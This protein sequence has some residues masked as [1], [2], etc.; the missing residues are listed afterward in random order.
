M[1]YALLVLPVLFVFRSPHGFPYPSEIARYSDFTLTH[2]A[3]AL[4]IQKELIGGRGVPLWNPYIYSGTPFFANPL[5]GLTYPPGWLAL[6]FP[7]PFGLNFCLALHLW[8]GSIGMYTWLKANAISSFPALF[9]ATGFI[10]LPKVVAHYGAG[11]V[12]LLYAFA[13]TPWLLWA[14]NRR[15]QVW[16]IL[17]LSLVVLADV[18]WGIYAIFLWAFYYLYKAISRDWS[19][20]VITQATRNL[21]IAL[22]LCAPLLIPLVEFT[23]YS[24]RSDMRLE[25]HLIYS[26]PLERT[27]QFLFPDF[28]GFHEWIVYPGATITLMVL[29]QFFRRKRDTSAQFWMLISVIAL[30]F[31]YGGNLPFLKVLFSLPVFDLL[32]V[33]SRALFLVG[34]GGLVLAAHTLE[35]LCNQAG[36]FHLKRVNLFLFGLLVF[37]W[38]AFFGSWWLTGERLDNVLWGTI[39]VSCTSLL[40]LVHLNRHLPRGVIL[41]VIFALGLLD[42]GITDL[43]L[44]SV[45][46]ASDTTFEHQD[47]LEFLI[48]QQDG[49]F[50][51]YSP[52]YSLPQNLAVQYEIHLVEGVDPLQLKD[53]RTF[54][55]LASGVPYT[56][57][58]V[59]LPAFE[60]GNPDEDTR[61]Y[62]PNAPLLG[63]L[64]VRF[65]ISSFRL[66]VAGLRWLKELDQLYLYENEQYRPRAWLESGGSETERATEDVQIVLWTPNRIVLHANGPG[67]LVLS[68]MLYPSWKARVDGKIVN[69]EPVHEIFR[70]V[71]L[72]SGEHIIEFTIQ[73]WSLYLG[74]FL[75]VCALSILA[76]LKRRSNL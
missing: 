63:W 30:L 45:K 61:G 32:R 44:Y 26:F 17:F 51:V 11:H 76:L 6:L 52:T 27:L 39:V 48:D 59:T 28:G 72:D 75:S 34:L 36:D 50:R 42:W 23:R 64:N 37:C 5:S 10:L 33:P 71:Q 31:S 35:A 66:E 29:L 25:D 15:R 56:H 65:V 74:L 62:T 68:E 8:L 43:S 12:S 49:L 24:T 70:G 40:I 13:W 69:I 20:S 7:L 3:H 47:L 14:I 73:P 55:V 19:F 41:V 38:G 22:S 16:E 53:Y 2:Y 4:F 18:R 46:L 1:P 21:S 67:R 57:Y 9:S 60:S 54:F 58:Q